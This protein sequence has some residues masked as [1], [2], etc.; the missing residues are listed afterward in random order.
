[1]VYSKKEKAASSFRARFAG[2]FAAEIMARYSSAPSIPPSSPFATVPLGSWPVSP[3]LHPSRL[4]P[5][6]KDRIHIH[7]RRRTRPRLLA[8][9][10]HLR[11]PQRLHPTH[12]QA[13][14]WRLALHQV[15][16]QGAVELD[17]QTVVPGTACGWGSAVEITRFTG[18]ERMLLF[19]ELAF[20]E[21]GHGLIRV[22]EGVRV[23]KHHGGKV[24]EAAGVIDLLL[25]GVGLLCHG[26]YAA[27]AAAAVRRHHARLVGGRGGVMVVRAS[28]VIVYC[29]ARV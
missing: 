3:L 20:L 2:R 11:A 1:M 17:F 18:I 22:G 19:D 5:V 4:P 13:H 27:A 25:H 26:K 15:W 23:G 7:P 29:G 8:P 28:A 16:R 21:H 12:R 10:I 9:P 6:A 24:G 14:A